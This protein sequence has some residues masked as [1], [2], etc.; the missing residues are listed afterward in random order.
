M[1]AEVLFV[2]Q[3]KLPGNQ[4]YSLEDLEFPDEEVMAALLTQFYQGQRFIPDEILLPVALD[5]AAVREEYF[6]EQKGKKVAVLNP[7]RGDKR[8]L[9][10]MAATN[11][12]QSFSERHDQEKTREKML[13]ELQSQLRL[14]NFPQRIECYD[15][16]NIHGVHAVG[17]LVTFVNGEPDKT[18]YRHHRISTID[19]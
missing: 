9:V 1:E 17:S 16:S 2:R 13:L 4:S 6:A 15:I 11:A 7:Q 14:K 10:E 12:R 18:R 3:G 19:P 5:D 8:Q